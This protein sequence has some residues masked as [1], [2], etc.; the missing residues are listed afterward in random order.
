MEYDGQ[1]LCASVNHWDL[2]DVK[3]VGQEIRESTYGGAAHAGEFETSLYLALKP[4]LVEMDKAVDV[5][6]PLPPSFQIDL[7]A[8]T[9]PDGSGA[10][11][12]PYW[13]SQTPNGV[14]GDAT[15]ATREKGEKWLAAAV[16]S[17]VDLIRELRATP[18]PPRHNQH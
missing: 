6:S 14:L 5:R 3:K 7:L 16:G 8:G 13:S 17:L 9:H 15:L 4:E 18:V 12:T 10:H 11:L 2:R 1:I